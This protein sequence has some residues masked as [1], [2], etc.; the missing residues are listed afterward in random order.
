MAE[1]SRVLAGVPDPAVGGRRHVVRM[2]AARHGEIGD[3]FRARQRRDGACE[4]QGQ[5][6]SGHEGLRRRR[7]RAQTLDA[8]SPGRNSPSRSKRGV[9][10]RVYF[11]S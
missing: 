4:K 1:S 5:P 2:V 8:T 11:L 6:H 10:S 3:A 7:L 9:Q